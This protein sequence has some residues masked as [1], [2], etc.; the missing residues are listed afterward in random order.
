MLKPMSDAPRDDKTPI[1]ILTPVAAHRAEWDS[2]FDNF[3]STTAQR[4]MTEEESLGW[5]STNE[6]KA[7][8]L[9]TTE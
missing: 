9:Q 8:V 3:W 2:A 7:F 4:S 5:M 1:V 6:W